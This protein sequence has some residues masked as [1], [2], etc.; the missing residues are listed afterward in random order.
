MRSEYKRDMNHNYLILHKEGNIDT[1]S[2]QVRM[3]VGNVVPSFLKCRIQGV[4]GKFLVY[5]DITSRQSLLSYY[6]D[7]MFG[8]EELKFILEGFVRVMEDTAEYLVSPGQILLLPEY[9]YLE[10]EK[11]EMYFCFLPGYDHDIREQFQKL[12]EYFLPKINHEDE[13]AVTLGYG[14]YRRAMEDH[15]HLEDIKKELYQTYAE[16][17]QISEEERNMYGREYGAF[18]ASPDFMKRETAEKKGVETEQSETDLFRIEENEKNRNISAGNR[19][20]T[21]QKG[22]GIWKKILLCFAA[23][24]V[25]LGVA[26]GRFLGYIPDIGIYICLA[27]A[28]AGLAVCLPVYFLCSMEKK[29]REKDVMMDMIQKKDARE[30]S[31]H[32]NEGQEEKRQ[33]KDNIKNREFFYKNINEDKLRGETVVLSAADLKGPASFVSREPGELAAIYL[34]DEIT[35]IGKLETACD[36]VIDLP[37]VSRLHAKVRKRDGEYYLADLNSRN[38]TAVNGR[39]LK[40]EEEYQL[41][42]EDEVDFAQARYVFLK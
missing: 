20:E 12:T 6:E 9:M 16:P 32:R 10:P 37:T 19:K 33:E 39:L 34:K 2:Y 7:R 38:G 1:D 24:L 40:S 17:G 30:E 15:F 23:A 29:K 35:V 5:Y 18:D 42:D 28:A 41:Q 36:A 13:R 8:Y 3:L 31:L 14:V 27:A 22:K 21:L 25:V 4:D 26:A 11:K